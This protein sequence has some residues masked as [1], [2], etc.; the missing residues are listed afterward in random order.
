MELPKKEEV[1]TVGYEIMEEQELLDLKEI[2]NRNFQ[3]CRSLP[4]YTKDNLA[5]IL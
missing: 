5:N 4:E 2:L 1:D 3:C